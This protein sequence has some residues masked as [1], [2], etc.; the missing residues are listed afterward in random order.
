MRSSVAP[1]IRHYHEL[2][3]RNL[4]AA[5]DQLDRLQALQRERNACFDGRPLAHSLR[6][7]F[8][9]ER[10]Y[11]D[12]QDAVYLIRQAVLTIAATFFGDEDLLRD[13][14]GMDDWEIEL[15]AIPTNVLRLSA[16]A[17]MDA[18]LTED[19]FKFVEL[20]GESPA[21]IAY[22]HRL[23]ELFRALP[24]FQQFAASYPV[25]F[26]SPLEHTIQSFLRVYHEEFGGEEAHP[27]VAIVDRL[28]DVP[29]TDEFH[30]LQEYLERHGHT[31]VIAD[32]RAL[33]CRDGW[34][35]ADGTRIDLLYRRLL[36]DEFQEIRDDC[37]AYLEGYRAQNTCYLNT[38]RAK[39]VHKKAIFSFLTDET[40]TQ[41]LSPPQREA[42]QR[43]IPWTRR[44]RPQTTSFR[45]LDIDLLEFVRDNQRYFIVKPNDEYGGAGV[46]LGF[47]ASESE[48]ETAL[49]HGVETGAV[50]QEAVNIHREPFLM[51]TDDG[52]DEVPTI[53]DLDP[54]VNG[55][56][57]GGCLSRISAT[58]LANVTAG[59][60]TLPTFI[61]R[62]T[63]A[64]GPAPS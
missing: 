25:R 5:D 10:E 3:A 40:F 4:S 45:G 27:T 11:A 16:N 8:L 46:T 1:A 19:T 53:I 22:S 60:G 44:L 64:N 54:Y 35:Y 41:V 2:I 33:D 62:N 15:A 43:H 48:W 47:E 49:D 24:V 32:P 30:L 52:W 7:T 18:F 42:I 34:V 12:V 37:G 55:P 28:E 61:L 58:N 59:G 20:N 13:R 38:F 21:G 51:P 31:C 29:T 39:L 57:V 50:V 36:M 23:Q 63:Y 56:L 6:P 9:T 17:R 26:V 14:L